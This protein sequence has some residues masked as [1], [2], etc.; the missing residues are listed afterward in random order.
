[1]EALFMQPDVLLYLHRSGRENR[2]LLVVSSSAPFY[3]RYI[4]NCDIG[5]QF[6]F[7]SVLE[8]QKL[9]KSHLKFSWSNVSQH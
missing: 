5:T 4:N 6:L 2:Y 1:M 7:L 3:E 8:E 9:T